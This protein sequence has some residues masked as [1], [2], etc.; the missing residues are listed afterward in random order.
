M[1]RYEVKGLSEKLFA[2]QHPETKGDASLRSQVASAQMSDMST[3]RFFRTYKSAAKQQWINKVKKADWQDG[4]EPT[5]AGHTRP[6]P[7]R[8]RTS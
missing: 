8:F 2:L 6:R 4:V 3:K 5:F 1:I 7:K